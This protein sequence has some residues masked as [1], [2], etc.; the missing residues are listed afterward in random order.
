MDSRKVSVNVGARRKRTMN[1]YW[2][3][4]CY[5]EVSVLVFHSVSSGSQHAR[6]LLIV[7]ATF[8]NYFCC[9]IKIMFR[10]SFLFGVKTEKK[11]GEELGSYQTVS[12][13]WNK[14]ERREQRI[15]FINSVCAHIYSTHCMLMVKTFF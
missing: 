8:V 5:F 1:Y 2:N 15:V 4:C 14:N 7:T 12:A 11:F 13:H 10:N 9:C 3:I 6:F